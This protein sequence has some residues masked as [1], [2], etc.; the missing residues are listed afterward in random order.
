ML[1]ERGLEVPVKLE[2]QRLL[3]IVRLM[4]ELYNFSVIPDIVVFDLLYHIINHGHTTTDV[5]SLKIIGPTAS[6]PIARYDQAIAYDPRIPTEFDP[7]AEPLRI[8]MVCEILNTCGQYY[9]HGK[10][11]RTRLSRFLLFFQRYLFTKAS[12]PFHVDFTLV[13]TLDKIEELGR[14]AFI[15][16]ETKKNAKFNKSKNS[17]SFK[18][19]TIEI[20]V[21]Y[22]NYTKS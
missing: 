8:L 21:Y 14:A 13:D 16:E 18:A 12:L 4:G 17:K 5:S 19:Q 22:S 9:V 6:H 10:H 1:I 3:G 15:S 7:P 2:T 11:K 20:K